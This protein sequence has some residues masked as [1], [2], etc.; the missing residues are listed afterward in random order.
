[1]SDQQQPYQQAPQQPYQQPYQQ[2]PQQ[3]QNQLSPNAELNW[4]AAAHWSGAVSALLGFMTFIGPVLVF[5]L[6]GGRSRVV[7]AHA[8]DAI[9]FEIS[10][11]LTAIG[12]VLGSVVLMFVGIGFLTIWMAPLVG[13]F[14]IVCH[15]LGAVRT[16]NGQPWRYPLTYPFIKG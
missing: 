1:M 13:I 15:F 16:I 10:M 11:W 5:F 12:I 4:A 7:R 14:V 3:Q 8:V 6:A 2:S 9:N